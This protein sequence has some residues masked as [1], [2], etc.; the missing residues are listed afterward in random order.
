MF[1]TGT[2]NLKRFSDTRIVRHP[3][4]KLDKNP[5]LD[6]EYFNWRRAKIS[7]CKKVN[8]ASSKMTNA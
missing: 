8:M 1:S 3:N 6:M 7:L 2:K 5:Y 4:V